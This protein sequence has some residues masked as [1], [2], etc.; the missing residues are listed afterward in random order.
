VRAPEEPPPIHTQRP[1]NI[2]PTCHF[3]SIISDFATEASKRLV[4]GVPI[5]EVLGPADPDLS[6]FLYPNMPNNGSMI[7]TLL[8]DILRTYSLIRGPPEKI[9]CLMNMLTILRWYIS[10]TLDNYN[11]MPEYVRPVE[12]QV[13]VP[14]PIWVDMLPW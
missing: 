14:H 12:A 7:T 10:P 4:A 5:E 1:N 9:C 2:R 13:R 3:D 6:T 8:M 11:A